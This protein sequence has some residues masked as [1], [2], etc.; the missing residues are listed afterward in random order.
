MISLK[1]SMTCRS[2]SYVCLA[3]RSAAFIKFLPARGAQCRVKRCHYQETQLPLRPGDVL[4]LYTDGV[5]EA[6]NNKGKLYGFERF[7]ASIE[8]G[9]GLSAHA[10]LEKLTD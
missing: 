6:M 1:A 3:M 5:V 7:M 8:A 9:R 10:L 4:V 2:K